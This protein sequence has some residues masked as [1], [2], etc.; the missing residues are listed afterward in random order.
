MESVGVES[1]RH[2]R[3]HW[4]RQQSANQTFPASGVR[5]HCQWSRTIKT[6]YYAPTATNQ[7]VTPKRVDASRNSPYPHLTP[8]PHSLFPNTYLTL[9]TYHVLSRKA[10]VTDIELLFLSRC[11]YP[12]SLLKSLAKT[13]TSLNPETTIY[14]KNNTLSIANWCR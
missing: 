12:I 13:T 7:R 1:P 14:F 4:S 8:P 2:R 9:G 3:C 6:H 10:R 11:L 5:R